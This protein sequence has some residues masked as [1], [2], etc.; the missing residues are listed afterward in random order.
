MKQKQAKQSKSIQKQSKTK[1]KQA[2]A[3]KSKQK[4]SKSKQKQAKASNSK[5]KTSTSMQKQA[6]ASKSKQ[7]LFGFPTFRKHPKRARVAREHFRRTF[8]SKS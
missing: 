5:Q 7:L 2:N 4:A 1:Q 8:Q 6:K 3:S